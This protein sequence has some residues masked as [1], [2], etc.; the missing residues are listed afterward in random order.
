MKK[1]VSVITVLAVIISMLTAISVFADTATTGTINAYG[2]DATITD[3]EANNALKDAITWK[4]NESTKTITISVTARLNNTESDATAQMPMLIGENR[5]YNSYA[6]VAEKVVFENG[7][8]KIGEWT[9]AEFTALKS[10][11]FPTSGLN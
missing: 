8:T 9:F 4:W 3:N 7:I 6:A 11:E 10:I 2:Y 5:P 1:I